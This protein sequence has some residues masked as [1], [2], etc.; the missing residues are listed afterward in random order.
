MKLRFLGLH[1]PCLHQKDAGDDLQAVG[2]AMLQFLEQHI[3]V[4]QQL[5][6]FTLQDAL[7]GDILDAKQNGGV[8]TALVEH[9]AGVQE[10]GALP[11]VGKHMLDLV[12]LHHA[13]LG[14]DFFQEQAK[15]GNVP[16]TVAQG[17]KRPALGV[18]GANLERRIE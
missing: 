1:H 4:D 2:Y 17:V 14:H 13:T 3:L 6:F 8:G 9:L 11:D 7:D 18:L 10:H 16:L 12:V 5:V 15:S